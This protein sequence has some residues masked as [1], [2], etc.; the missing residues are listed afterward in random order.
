M[1]GL[2]ALLVA[3]LYGTGL[4]LMLRR[5][6]L[7]LLIG[8]SLL[9]HG[10]NI[11]LLA[12][13][14]PLRR[15]SPIIPPDADAPPIDAADP[16]PQAMILTAIVISMAVVAFAVVL[17]HRARQAIGSGDVDDLRTTDR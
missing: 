1:H 8:L 2:L 6:S 11:L 13:S 17:V 16:L 3:A 10:A 7:K 5:S 12:A 4:Y 9:A 15:V 14:G